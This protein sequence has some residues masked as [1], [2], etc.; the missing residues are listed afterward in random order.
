MTK[1]TDWR[2]AHV[3]CVQLLHTNHHFQADA[4]SLRVPGER[5]S[6]RQCTF[7][8]LAKDSHFCI[9]QALDID[10]PPFSQVNFGKPE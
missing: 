1:K 10:C 6:F 8:V 7:V 3:C 5:A 4:Q 9:I 2:I